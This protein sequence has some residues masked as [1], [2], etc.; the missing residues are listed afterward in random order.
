MRW[1][2]SRGVKSTSRLRKLKRTPRTPA[3]RFERI[4][5]GAI[6]LGMARGLDDHVLVEA[7]EV[8]QREQLFLRRIARRVFALGRVRKF[9]LG[10]EHVAVRINRVRWRLESRLRW[11][12]M[13]RDV[14]RR[15]R[16]ARYSFKP[17]PPPATR[18]ARHQRTWWGARVYR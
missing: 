16:H 13:E 9:G 11:I 10:A 14:A 18:P 15:H 3:R 8:A 2:T 4:D 17:S 5:H 1:S 7:E 6:V 12:G